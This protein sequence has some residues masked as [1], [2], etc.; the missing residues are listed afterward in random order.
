MLAIALAVPLLLTA[1]TDKGDDVPTK[2]QADAKT[3]VQAQA[4]QVAAL[5]GSPLINPSLDPGPCT[6]PDGQTGDGIYTMQGAYQIM[7]PQADHTATA[8]KIR[9]AWKTAGWNITDDRTVGTAAI[10]S[11]TSTD[12]TYVHLESTTPPKAFALIVRS[13]CFQAPA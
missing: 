4:E 12:G 10:I 6:D 13:S 3:A 7:V 2:S 11:A 5:I 8:T 9:D 1:C